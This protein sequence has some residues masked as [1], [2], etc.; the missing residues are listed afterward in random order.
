MTDKTD[1]EEAKEAAAEA[2]EAA[3]VAEEEADNPNRHPMAPNV[4]GTM[5]DE[6]RREEGRDRP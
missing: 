5:S 2:K 6:E 4:T 3:K 1:K